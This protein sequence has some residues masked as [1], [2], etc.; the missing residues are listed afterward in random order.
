M[1]PRFWP[2]RS[3]WMTWSGRPRAWSPSGLHADD[4]TQHFRLARFGCAKKIAI[5]I[6]WPADLPGAVKHVGY[7]T[8]VLL[9]HAISIDFPLG[10]GKGCTEFNV[11]LIL[12]HSA[13]ELDLFA[14][15]KRC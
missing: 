12:V 13:R 11:P 1:R 2:P 14:C 6:D 3:R 9:N 8:G 7:A 4:L 10:F 5:E 15:P